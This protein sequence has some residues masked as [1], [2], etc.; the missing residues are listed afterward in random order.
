MLRI[1]IDVTEIKLCYIGRYNWLVFGI[2]VNYNFLYLVF[3]FQW[4]L[5]DVEAWS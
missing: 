3:W 4:G 5:C 2:P 1:R